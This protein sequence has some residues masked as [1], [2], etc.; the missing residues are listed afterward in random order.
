MP[1][2]VQPA[3]RAGNTRQLVLVPTR[4]HGVEHLNFFPPR[5]VEPSS[6]YHM[7]FQICKQVA[8]SLLQQ[9][10]PHK[11]NS[12]V[13]LHLEDSNATILI[14]MVYGGLFKDV[15]KLPCHAA[16]VLC[17][18]EHLDGSAQTEGCQCWFFHSS[19]STMN[20]LGCGA[21]ICIC[22][23]LVINELLLEMPSDS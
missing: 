9:S 11:E 3:W 8:Q 22:L 10:L 1:L 21:R 12:T 16:T 4:R 20:E 6:S 17:L 7:N 18:K 5:E 15:S 14:V 19:R 13:S 23:P 2:F